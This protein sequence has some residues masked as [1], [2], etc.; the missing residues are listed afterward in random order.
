MY[1]LMSNKITGDNIS[2]F[3]PKTTNLHSVEKT[4]TAIPVAEV[5][6]PWTAVGSKGEIEFESA[7]YPDHQ[8]SLDCATL[9]HRD[10]H[11]A[12]LDNWAD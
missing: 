2:L 1:I 4:E 9:N 10:C 3:E 12:P 6:A 7:A 5:L 8:V 11:L